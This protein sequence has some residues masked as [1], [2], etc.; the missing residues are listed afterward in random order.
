[1]PS[2]LSAL[3]LC[4]L[5]EGDPEPDSLVYSHGDATWLAP[6]L[7]V[8]SDRVAA[9]PAM[10]G[11]NMPIAFA[12]TGGPLLRLANLLGDAD[13]RTIG[14]ALTLDD[15]TRN[16]WASALR[17]LLAEVSLSRTTSP[18][19]RDR[20]PPWSRPCRAA[21]TSGPPR[22]ADELGRLLAQPELRALLSRASRPASAT[23]DHERPFARLVD[24]ELQTGALQ[25]V[26]VSDAG[27]EVVGFVGERQPSAAAAAE[28][29]LAYRALA[30][31][32]R[33]AAAEQF[34]IA[35]ERVTATIAFVLSGH[36][37]RVL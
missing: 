34:E 10:L 3:L 37:V 4:A 1:M 32:W 27:V 15:L 8:V 18:I 23:V 30:R 6:P 28:R 24:G 19:G 17:A 16:H 31:A 29:A 36:V 25:R 22:A 9:Q 21:R 7:K 35:E 26:V 13:K 14:E 5:A 20:S 11:L 2:R 33:Q 12:P